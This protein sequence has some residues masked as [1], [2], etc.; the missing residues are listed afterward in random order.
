MK[1]VTIVFNKNMKMSDLI[2]ADYHLLQL[3]HRL[4]ISLGFGDKSIKAVCEANGFD[5]DCFIFLANFQSNKST[6]NVEEAFESLPLKP[7]LDYL[8]MSHNH[9]INIQL[10]NLRRKLKNLLDSSDQNISEMILRF[11]DRY[12]NDVYEHMTYEDEVVFPYIRSLLNKQ[13]YQEDYTIDVFKDRHDDIE[14]KM[15]ELKQIL[16]KYI[17]S[18][19]GDQLLLTNLL[20][21][22]YIS[23]EDLAV[24][25]YIEDELVIPRVRHIECEL[26]K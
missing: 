4:N 12:S 9:F 20:M 24:H 25:T 21:D 1:N 6:L 13:L 22:L 7:F 14:G 15:D 10:P 19:K 11:F 17:P 8:E 16:L 2:D 23:E 5:A 3:L 18:E 26:K